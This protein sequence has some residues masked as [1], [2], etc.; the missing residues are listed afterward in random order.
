[1][2]GGNCSPPVPLNT[3]SVLQDYWSE[4][5]HH[6]SPP[7]VMHKELPKTP[8]VRGKNPSGPQENSTLLV[9]HCAK[10]EP[11]VCV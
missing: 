2:T 1:M 8:N 10:I 3:D 7:T 11:R 5:P 4:C 9:N 6:S